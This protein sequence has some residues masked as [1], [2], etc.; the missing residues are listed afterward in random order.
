VGLN[1]WIVKFLVPA[2]IA[3]SDC[4]DTLNDRGYHMKEHIEWESSSSDMIMLE[5]DIWKNRL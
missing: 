3:W 1:Q 2:V 5:N 4:S